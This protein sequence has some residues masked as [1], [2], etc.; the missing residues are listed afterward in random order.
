ML[1]HGVAAVGAL[2]LGF[3]VKLGLLRGKY[4]PA[5]LHAVEASYVFASSLG[6]FRAANVRSVWTSKMP[7]ANTPV[8][9]NLLGGPVGVDP[10]FYIVWTRFRPVRRYLAHRPLEVSRIYRMLDS[11]AHGA[12]GHSLVHLLLISAAEIGFAW[13]GEQQG[14]IRAALPPPSGC[15]RG[16]FQLAEREGF[17]GAQFLDIREPAGT[18]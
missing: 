5:G 4:L 12:P 2:P 9:L 13:D 8:V 1:L 6:A 11:I 16:P 15:W 7:L 17:Q 3:E 10:A 14:W 18:R